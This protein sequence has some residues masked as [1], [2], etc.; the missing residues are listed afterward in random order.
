VHRSTC[1][2]TGKFFHKHFVL[3]QEVVSLRVL[4]WKHQP[5]VFFEIPDVN[6]DDQTSDATQ[7]DKLLQ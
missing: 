6:D 3:P 1:M 2:L 5:K 4:L 7:P